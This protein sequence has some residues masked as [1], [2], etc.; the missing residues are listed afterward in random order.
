MKILCGSDKIAVA[1]LIQRA[2]E[3]QL[4]RNLRFL[5]MQNT[6]VR[7]KA[8]KLFFRSLVEVQGN[9]ALALIWLKANI[10]FDVCQ[11]VM[12]DWN[13]KGESASFYLLRGS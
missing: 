12:S 1:E 8:F 2:E 4:N 5:K 13:Y 6:P 11:K 9:H 10:D 3:D 7:R